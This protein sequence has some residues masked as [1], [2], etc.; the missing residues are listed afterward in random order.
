MQLEKHWRAA[1]WALLDKSLILVFGLAF[2]LV[3]VRALP[4]AE[5]GLQA[6][7]ST[8]L[9]TLAPLLRMLFLVPST[10]FV[11]EGGEVERIAVTGTLLYVAACACMAAVLVAG[12]DAWAA[13]FDKPDLAAVLLPSGVLLLVGSGRDAAIAT[14]EGHRLLRRVFLADLAYYALAVGGLLAWRWLDAP[15]DAATV[16]WVQAAA[17]GAGSLLALGAAARQLAG[18]PAA[19]Q[20][21]RILGFGRYAF[22]SGLGSNVGQQ[23]DSLLAGALMPERGVA[24]YQAAKLFFRVFN[25]VAQALGQLLMPLVSR[26]Q[27]QGRLHDV[28]T[29]FEKSACFTHLALVPVIGMLLLLATPLY[30]LFYGDRYREDVGVFRI[31]LLAALTVPLAST[32]APFLMG[33]GRVRGL[34]VITWLG[35]L[36]A[37]AAALAWIPTYGAA[38]AAWANLAG[39]LVVVVGIAAVLRAA[40]RFRVRD[41]LGRTRDA[42]HFVGRRLAGWRWRAR[43]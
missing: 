29:L 1:T 17:A 19:V 3:V 40:L 16:Q 25:V 8:V 27:A 36:A 34:L 5:F 37:I 24:A 39:R 42:T 33:L 20:A 30:A 10:K 13:M 18:R 32:V 2:M 43:A 14:L 22:G 9:L 11:A 15:R 41:V 26:L 31:L 12:R 35:T 28:R 4:E 21:R 6:I 38:G 7:A 23:A